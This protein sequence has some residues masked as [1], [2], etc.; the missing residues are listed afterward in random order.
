VREDVVDHV[1][2]GEGYAVGRDPVDEEPRGEAGE[3]DAEDH[4]QEP[5]ELRLLRGGVPY[6]DL[7]RGHHGEDVEDGE[8]E[9]V[10]GLGEVREPQEAAGP[11]A[12]QRVEVTDGVV[13][14]DEDG[15]LDE[16]GQAS[17]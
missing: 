2:L 6:G 8:D 4:G 17:P 1:V 3:E 11:E 13:E 9:E 7:L 5:H 12:L 14:D 10:V 15:E 16:D